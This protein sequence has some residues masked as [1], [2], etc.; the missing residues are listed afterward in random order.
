[1]G[2]VP[3]SRPWLALVVWRSWRGARAARSVVR[4]CKAVGRTADGAV[5]DM[6]G[7]ECGW[8]WGGLRRASRGAVVASA[9]LASLRSA[10]WRVM[11]DAACAN[12]PKRPARDAGH[13]LGESI[14]HFISTSGGPSADSAERVFGELHGVV[15]TN[16]CLEQLPPRLPN[17]SVLSGSW[18]RLSRS[19]RPGSSQAFCNTP[20]GRLMPAGGRG[21]VWVPLGAG[22][23]VVPCTSGDDLLLTAPRATYCWPG[24]P[25][26]PLTWREPPPAN[27]TSWLSGLTMTSSEW[28]ISSMQ[29][30]A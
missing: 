10:P 1:M 18:F 3:V 11:A 15:M 27:E 13:R 17:V 16:V 21:G 20:R 28:H 12:A 9:V 25:A 19:L 7:G 4:A 6:G 23:I 14:A 8:R 22:G 26:S 30:A 5:G 24:N 29:L 2:G